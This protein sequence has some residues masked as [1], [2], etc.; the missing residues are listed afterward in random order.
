MGLRVFKPLLAG[1]MCRTYQRQGPRLAVT[2]LLG[3]SLKDPEIPLTEQEMWQSI[4]PFLP[5]D[6]AFD[7][8]IP[9]DRGEFLLVGHCHAVGGIPVTSRRISVRVGALGKTLDVF[10][11]RVWVRDRGFRRKGEPAPFVMMPID[12]AHA[13]GGPG[14]GPNPTGK[15]FSGSPGEGPLP[16]ANIE[17]PQEPFSSPEDRPA[18]AGFG[19]LEILWTPR[20]SRVGRYRPG[21]IGKDPPPLPENADWTLYN[22]APSDQWLRGFWEGG[23]SFRLEGLQ[24]G[25]GL[26][27]G[28]LPRMVLRS[29]V[30]RTGGEARMVPLHPETVWFFPEISVG[31]VIHRGSLP[32]ADEEGSDISS[33]LLAMEDPGEEK[34]AEHYIA[35]R[36]RRSDRTARDPSRFA[37]GPLLPSRLASDPR[38]RLLDAAVHEASPASDGASR[39]GERVSGALEKARRKLEA[40]KERLGDPSGGKGTVA[41]ALG[42]ALVTLS[43]GRESGEPHARGEKEKFRVGGADAAARARAALKEALG[44]IPEEVLVRA[45]ITRESLLESAT[46]APEAPP[47]EGVSPGGP[48]AALKERLLLG[49][50]SSRPSGEPLPESRSDLRAALERIDRAQEQLERSGVA[51]MAMEGLRPNLHHFRPP[52]HDPARAARLRAQVL[53]ER[54]RGRNFQGA[55]LRGA[56]LSELDLSGCDF[57]EGDLIGADLSRTNLSGAR[58]SGAWMAHVSLSGCRLDGTDF[59]GAALG[60]ANLTGSR[61]AGTLFDKAV[62]SGAVF[63]GC[64]LTEGRFAGAA[65]LGSFFRGARI[66]RSDLAG[67]KFLVTGPLPF[68]PAGLPQRPEGER[69]DLSEADFSGCNMTGALFMKSDF[70]GS[71]LTGCILSKATFL[72]CTGRG[73]RFS[74][75][76]LQKSAFPN[77]TDFSRSDFR[78]ADLAGANLRGVDLSG[79]DFRGGHLSGADLSG[80]RWQGA[81]MSGLSAV[82][83]RFIHADLRG[84]DGRGGDFREAQFLKAD[85]RSADF[86]HGSL[87][88]AGFTGAI[89]DET[90]R[91]DQ[92]LTGKTVLSGER[93]A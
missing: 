2:G 22:Q 5:K 55:R 82:G 27:E 38:A 14:Y 53:D 45:K 84:I 35:V 51:K 24:P 9:K 37:D 71:D 40:L 36:D 88:K 59:S 54:S 47:K 29:L 52:G 93:P 90:T 10:G 17:D 50:A 25:G 6:G 64:D 72:E 69:Q 87:Y 85:L 7:E 16:V 46:S 33:V 74:G 65:F 62:L 21:E 15:G 48:L 79:S 68:P 92:A 56:D 61:G 41:E 12:W 19:P 23:E 91:W 63:T 11:D 60:C 73:A 18:P 28:H 42:N 8:G 57:S 89:R 13:F 39:A 58:F 78:G 1:F 20:F 86:S 70:S 67:A 83:A 3:F 43:S 75:A 4:A 26:R 31:V 80:G 49:E 32:V 34:S 30:T 77:S 81:R 76:R 44:R 66:R